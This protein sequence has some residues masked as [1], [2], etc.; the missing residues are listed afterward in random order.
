M[1]YFIKMY[2]T[3]AQAKLFNYLLSSYHCVLAVWRMGFS[4]NLWNLVEGKYCSTKM[5]VTVRGARVTM[6][7]P[8]QDKESTFSTPQTVRK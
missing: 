8:N 3:N 7:P 5:T 2:V 1:F 6:A 4:R